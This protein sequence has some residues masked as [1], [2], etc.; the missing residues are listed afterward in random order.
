MLVELEEG[1]D[2][3]KRKVECVEIKIRGKRR[4]KRGGVRGG[5][6]L[7]VYRRI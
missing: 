1:R 4:L 7:V 2:F 6:V 3:F 5:V